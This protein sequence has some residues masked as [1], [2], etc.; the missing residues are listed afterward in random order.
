[1]GLNDPSPIEMG[2]PALLLLKPRGAL[3]PLPGRLLDHFEA[4][5]AISGL[6]L[7][8]FIGSPYDV[9]LLIPF[10]S[11]EIPKF[12][13]HTSRLVLHRFLVL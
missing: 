8:C 10:F 2:A 12:P 11:S 7:S 9:F 1:M 6:Q 4:D 3:L 5:E 13:C